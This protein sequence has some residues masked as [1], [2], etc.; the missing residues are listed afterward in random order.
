MSQVLAISS[1]TDVKAPEQNLSRQ[2]SIDFSQLLEDEKRKA[3]FSFPLSIFQSF[4]NVPLEF[5]KKIGN[6]AC[7][8]EEKSQLNNDPHQNLGYT[9][10]VSQDKNS[11][12][13]IPAQAAKAEATSKTSNIEQVKFSTNAVNKIFAGNI[14]LPPDFYNVLITA[15]NRIAT[16]R[17]IDVDDLISQIQNKIKMLKEN[18]KVELTIE[19][20]PE[21][22]GA[23]MMNISSN[24]GVLSINIYADKLA[25]EALEDNIKELERSLKMANLNIGSLY[26]FPDDKRKNNRG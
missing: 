3:L 18:G 13:Q 20:K 23:I 11:T 22:L 17:K 1:E 6:C 25:R 4:F 14:E 26:V 9:D 16:L 2:S 12:D 24:K 7:K 19:L 15:K 5:D 8:V 10:R 21:N